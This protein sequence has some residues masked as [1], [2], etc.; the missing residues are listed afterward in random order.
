MPIS[1]KLLLHLNDCFFVFLQSL[2]PEWFI[3]VKIYYDLPFLKM[4]TY[5]DL[6][7]HYHIIRSYVITAVEEILLNYK[8]Q[9]I[10]E[11]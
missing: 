4:I 5:T 2:Q 3:H 10:L 9:S 11:S 6:W 8:N 1:T 7:W